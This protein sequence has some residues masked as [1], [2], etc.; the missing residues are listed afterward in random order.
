VYY[1]QGGGLAF[2]YD[3]RRS[4]IVKVGPQEPGKARVHGAEIPFH[5]AGYREL[6]VVRERG[7]QGQL[8][9]VWVRRIGDCIE[10]E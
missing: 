4:V 5:N 2:L 3:R 7:V 10:V 9:Y 1:D 8:L 6:E